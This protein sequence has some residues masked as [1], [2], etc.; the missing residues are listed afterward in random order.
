MNSLAKT[1]QT[2]NHPVSSILPMFC[3]IKWSTGQTGTYTML[4]VLYLEILNLKPVEIIK[5]IALKKTVQ[6]QTWFKMNI[7]E[8]NWQRK[9]EHK[10]SSIF[11]NILPY[12]VIRGFKK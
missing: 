11:L 9:K 2:Q 10:Q 5:S 7:K 4:Q 12:S 3:K 1:L 6:S 8:N